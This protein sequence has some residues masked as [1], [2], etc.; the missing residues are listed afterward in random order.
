MSVPI[1][2]CYD[3]KRC[4]QVSEAE[5]YFAGISD[6]ELTS[7]VHSALRQYATSRG[8]VSGGVA[9]VDVDSID[10]WTLRTFSTTGG[11]VIRDRHGQ[12]G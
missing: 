7:A 10:A 9:A 4:P 1:C 6:Q 2:R 5:R 12:Q 11:S 3:G 8:A